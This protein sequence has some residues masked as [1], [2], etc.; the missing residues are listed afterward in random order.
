MPPLAIT[1]L[2]ASAPVRAAAVP[3]QR[4]L[5]DLAQTSGVSSRRHAGLATVPLPA[6]A[7]LLSR[8]R[9]GRLAAASGWN[10]RR[11]P[12]FRSPVPTARSAPLLARES[13]GE[14]DGSVPVKA[15]ASGVRG[16]GRDQ[17]FAGDQGRP[18]RVAAASASHA[19]GGLVP[20]GIRPAW[21]SRSCTASWWQRLFSTL[22]A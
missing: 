17:R 21:M 19:G 18:Q 12:R 14:R 10:G 8:V 16:T 3:P 15:E 20:T 9:L 1:R 2:G 11:R 5:L 6:W 7:L 13:G 4:A 22:L